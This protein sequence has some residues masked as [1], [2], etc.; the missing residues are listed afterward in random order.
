MNDR[1]FSLQLFARVARTGSFS[2]AGREKGISQLTASRIVAVLEKKVGVALLTRSTRPAMRRAGLGLLSA[3]DLS[4]LTE[5]ETG[6]LLRVLLD[7]EMGSA[8]I[9]AILPGGRAANPPLALLQNLLP[10]SRKMFARSKPRSGNH[11]S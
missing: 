1:F 8:D 6:T 9:N 10:R 7:W 3:G 2:S 5:L 11:Q 4:A